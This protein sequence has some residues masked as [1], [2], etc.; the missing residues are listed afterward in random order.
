MPLKKYGVRRLA[1]TALFAALTVV[2][3]NI[4]QIP[5]DGRQFNFGFLPAAAA[6]Y[7][8]GIPA[9]VATAAIGD[10]IG[11]LLFPTGAFFPGFTLTAALV[12]LAYGLLLRGRRRSWPRVA[13]AMLLGAA[14][15]LFLNS[16]WLSIL[17][18]SKGYWAWVAVRAP[19]YLPEA[20]VQILLTGLA[21]RAIDRIPLPGWLK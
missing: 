1:V 8:L 2:L 16:Y 5:L 21:L 6:A 9:A 17:Y 19:S 11:A 3:G 10:I 14:V 12:A 13:A 20:P 4:T 7:L 15:N 18:T